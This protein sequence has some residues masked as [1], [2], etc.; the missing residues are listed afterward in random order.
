MHKKF[1]HKGIEKKWQEQWEETGIYD[2]ASRDE[3]KEKEYV[4]VEFPYPSG[5]LH[6]GHWFA[7]AVTDIYAR[8]H[9]MQGKQVFFPF[10]YDAFG[11]PAENAAIK[12]GL[13]P[14]EW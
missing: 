9:R 5:N 8:A 7:F 3:N 6:V 14:R 4:L 13:D 10:G 1:D 2:T 12:R 11:L